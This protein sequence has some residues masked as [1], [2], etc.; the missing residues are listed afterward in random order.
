[1][2]IV[3]GIAQL[4]AR[5][6]SAR[7]DGRRVAFVPTMG[8]LHSGH[9]SLLRAARSRGDCVVASIFVNRLQFGPGEDFD[10]YPRTF[11]SDCSMLASEGVDLVFAPDERE[12]YPAPQAYFVM[13]PPIGEELEGKFRPGFFRGVATV[14]LKLFNIVQPQVAVFGKKDYQQLLIVRGLVEQLALPLEIVAAETVRAED[15][16][17]LSSRNG[18]LSPT[19]RAIAPGLHRELSRVQT[20]IRAGRRDWN[21]LET[22]ASESLDRSGWRTDYVAIRRMADLAQP[23]ADEPALVLLAA[24]RLGNTRLIDNLEVVL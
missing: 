12:L 2:E 11:E 13:P 17:A 20:A 22:G 7:L 4:R 6:R 5:L 10:R 18:Y 24:S 15:G 1:M 3:P 21:A 8:N 14:V 23:A 9:M 16:L 19:D